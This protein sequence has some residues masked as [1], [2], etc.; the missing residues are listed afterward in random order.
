[1]RSGPTRRYGGG[2][3]SGIPAGLRQARTGETWEELGEVK[4]KG[5]RGAA[6]NASPLLYRRCHGIVTSIGRRLCETTDATEWLEARAILPW[7]IW[8]RV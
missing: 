6:P 4:G 8:G 1:M 3:G 2:G 5:Q 7:N